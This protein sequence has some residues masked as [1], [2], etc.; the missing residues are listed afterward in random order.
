MFIKFNANKCPVCGNNGN[1]LDKSLFECN[2]CEMAYDNFR[3]F[4]YPKEE[5]NFWN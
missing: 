1:K 4:G 3:F 2:K 5:E